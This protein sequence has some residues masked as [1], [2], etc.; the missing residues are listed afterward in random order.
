VDLKDHIKELLNFRSIDPLYGVFLARQLSRGSLE[1]KTQ[2]LESVLPVPP[3]IE[4][5][6]RLPELEP[7]P[8]QAQE[9]EPKLVQMGLVTARPEGGM[10]ALAQ[11]EEEDYWVEEDDSQRPL[12]LPEM[13]KLLFEARLATPE[14]VFVQPKWI[15]GGTLEFESD[16]YKFVRARNLVKNEGLVLRHL[17]RLVILAGEFLIQSDGDPDYERIGELAKGICERVDPRY[18]DRFLTSQAEATKLSDL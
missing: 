16:F 9:L 14:E 6:V 12:S 7:G 17:L 15:A 10:A 18:T 3:A 5:Q 1:E 2:A 11:D 13:L 8:L 4:R